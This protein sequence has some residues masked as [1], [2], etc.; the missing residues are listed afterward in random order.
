LSRIGVPG[1]DSEPDQPPAQARVDVEEQFL[2]LLIEMG[3]APSGNGKPSLANA[4]QAR[5]AAKG[6]DL[7]PSR[8]FVDDIETIIQRRIQLI[9][10]LAQKQLHIEP[11]P[12]GEVRFTF[13]G[14]DYEHVD[15]IPNLTAR[16][17]VRDA[18]Q[19]WDE[20]T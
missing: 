16:D 1:T 6:K 15:D 13:E 5:W 20:T 10:A 19:E 17:I 9:P 2:N 7:D 8:T 11:G 4:I 3:R 12:G 18:I 14:Q